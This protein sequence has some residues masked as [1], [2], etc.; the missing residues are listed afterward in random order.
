[1]V[2]ER[3]FEISRDGW[4][5]KAVSQ[6]T[7]NRELRKARNRD[8][9]RIEELRGECARLAEELKKSPPFP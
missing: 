9:Q 5:R 6:A 8:L 3:W 1:M 4:K 7:Q 2:R